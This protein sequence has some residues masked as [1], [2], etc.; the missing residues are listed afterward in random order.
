[1]SYTTYIFDLD[2]TLLDT[3]QDL[4][5]A[6]NYAMRQMNCPERTLD[7]VRRFIGDGMRKLI[8][9]SAPK[10]TDAEQIEKT[11][12][13]FKAY[14]SG[15]LADFTKP[16]DGI[17]NVIDTLKSQGKKL[18]VVS[19]KADEAAKAV[20]KEYFG[21]S[22]D[23]VVGQNDG[24]PAKPSPE[25]VNCVIKTLNADRSECIYI[26]DS[27]VDVLTAHNAGL[28]CIGVTWGNRG[29]QELVDSGAEYIAE[30][31][32]EIIKAAQI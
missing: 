21:D 7:E 15:H 26:G 6:V 8:E 16:Y 20:V 27:D 3:L 2:G 4:T 9:R 29:R 19:N 25:S 23:I 5:N 11:L 24:I 10:N 12:E 30:H 18:A 28:K 32:F 1:M 22:F 13:F 17:E 14:Y 31:P